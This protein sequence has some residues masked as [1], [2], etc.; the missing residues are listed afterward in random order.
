MIYFKSTS[1]TLVLN[2]KYMEAAKWMKAYNWNSY[3]NN[4]INS[5]YLFT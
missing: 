1:I 2:T 3:L 4:E 5:F